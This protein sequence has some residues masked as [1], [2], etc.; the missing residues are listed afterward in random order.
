MTVSLPSSASLPEVTLRPPAAS[1]D[2]ASPGGFAAMLTTLDQALRQADQAAAGYAQGRTGLTEAALAAER[3]DI[4]F[5]LAVA[6]RNRALAAYQQIA[7][8]SV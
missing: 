6:L 2:S 7:A 1:A 8:M 4:T 5:G 3:A